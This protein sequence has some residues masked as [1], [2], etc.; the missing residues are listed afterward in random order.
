MKNVKVTIKAAVLGVQSPAQFGNFVV[1]G[2]DKIILNQG[3]DDNIIVMGDTGSFKGLKTS[4]NVAMDIE[5]NSYTKDG[6]LKEFLNYVGMAK[7]A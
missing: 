6:Y 5:I 2:K 1:E 3:T 4:M 7:P